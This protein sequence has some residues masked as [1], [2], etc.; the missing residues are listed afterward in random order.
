[1]EI[2]LRRH[3]C[4]IRR[5]SRLR[6]NKRTSALTCFLTSNG[7]DF[8]RILDGFLARFVSSNADRFFDR[9]DEDFTVADFASL[10]RIYDSRDRVLNHAVNENHFDFD[11]W[12][13]VDC[14][15]TA[16]IN[17]CV[18]LH[19]YT[20]QYTRCCWLAPDAID[21]NRWRCE[22]RFAILSKIEDLPA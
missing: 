11:F 16:A 10:R 4:A 13:K 19:F 14:V 1:M 20:K 2:H 15:L 8:L 22:E 17:L 6:K 3:F 9:V 18:A 7:I 12:H 21:N 5:K